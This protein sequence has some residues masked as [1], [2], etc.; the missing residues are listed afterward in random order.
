MRR[1]LRHPKKLAWQPRYWRLHGPLGAA[2]R[3]EQELADAGRCERCGRLLTDP[4]SLADSIGPECRR[5]AR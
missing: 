3:I 4:K 2:E 5:K 1:S